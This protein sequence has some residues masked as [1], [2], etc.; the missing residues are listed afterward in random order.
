MKYSKKPL[1][2]IAN[3]IRGITFKPENLI[4]TNELG[5][6]VCMRTK[7]IQADLDESDLIAIPPSFVKRDE[8]YIKEG[9]ILVSTANSWELV[10]KACWVPKLDYTATA[11]GFISILRANQAM[12][13]PRYLYHWMVCTE[14]QHNLRYCG[15]QTTNISN[16]SFGLAEKLEIP[17]PPLDEQHRI[18][19]IL[20]KADAIRRK[21]QESIRL[22]EEFLR[23]TFLEMFGDIPAKKSNYN[24]GTLRGL[25]SAQSGKS[26]NQVLSQEKTDIPIYGGN[27]INGWATK[28][29]FEEKVVVVGR[30]GQ[31]CGIVHITEGPSWVT[32]NAIVIK[33]TDPTKLHPIYVAEALQKSPLRSTVEQLDLPFINQSTILD[34]PIP[35]PPLDKQ[36]DFVKIK[37]NVLNSRLKLTS[38]IVF[39]NLMFNSLIHRAFRGEL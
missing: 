28:S 19:A 27:G 35:I 21:R 16:M 30:V 1:G 11:G 13:F 33:V 3:F 31:Q 20:D 6:V 26:S 25:V 15:R 8:Q 34:Y 9:D 5:A 18:S 14:T 17:L 29:L 22:T 38:A 37:E 32:D 23:S 24:F 4:D 10:G 36:L 12:V 39:S 2:E 7:N